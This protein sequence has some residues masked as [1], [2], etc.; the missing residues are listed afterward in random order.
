[1]DKSVEQE[2]AGLLFGGIVVMLLLAAALVAFVLIYQKKLIGQQLALQTIQSAYQKELLVAAIQAEDRERERIGNDLHDELGSSLSMAKM[3]ISQLAESASASAKEQEVIAIVEGI[4]GDS[5]QNVRNISQSLHPAVLA[6]FGLTKAL[7]NLGF[8]CADA[9]ANGI[10]IQVELE[11]TLTQSQELALYR[12]VQEVVNNAMK[13]ARASRLTV[14]LQQ[15][16]GGLI[17]LITDDGCGFDYAAAQNSNRLGLGLKS[18]AARASLLDAAL[19]LESA[20]GRGTGVRV[21]MP[22]A[23]PVS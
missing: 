17:L 9:F 8:V 18:I 23:A 13:H 1:V 5:L 11:A 10:D 22:L 14:H 3:L 21:E 7:Q 19:H 2:I 16:S 12:I 4:L 15:H 20:P 6:R